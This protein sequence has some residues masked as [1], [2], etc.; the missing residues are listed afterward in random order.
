MLVAVAIIGIVVPV[1]FNSI[2]TLY[3]THA[4]TL[5]RALALVEAT[6][7]VKE[8]VRDVRAAVYAENG[9]LPLV[10][11]A[12]STITL[13]SDT[14][15]DGTVERV[16]YFLSG[17]SVQKGII[18]PTATSSYPTNTETVET[19]VSEVANVTNGVPLFRYYSAT[20]TEITTSSRMLDVRRVEV[21]F[22]GFSQFRSEQSEVAIRSSASIRNLK[23]VY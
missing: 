6:K 9:T 23:D 19:I 14:D 11:I 12:T 8:V 10:D 13:Y 17:T 2:I 22:V 3:D 4:R 21:Q 18:E 15:Y 20:S 1:L 16:R 7:G 5:S